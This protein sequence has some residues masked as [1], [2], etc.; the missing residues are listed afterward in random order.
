MQ[1]GAI[2]PESV[3]EWLRET[4]PLELERLYAEADRV[5]CIGVGDEVHLRGLIEI[6]NHCVRQCGY[7][8]LRAA[9]T[10]LTRYRMGTDDVL[11]C[12]RQAAQLGYGTAVLQAGEDY[13]LSGEWIAD[14]VRRIKSETSVAV[15]LSLGERSEEDLALWKKAGA[16][17]YLLRFETSDCDLYNLIHPSLPGGKSDRI[18]LLQKLHELGYEI[19]GGVMVGI[20][21]QSYGSLAEDI[22]TFQRLDLDMIG[23]GPFIPHPG[24]PLGKGEWIRPIAPAEQVPNTEQMVYKTLALARLF[25]PTANLPATTA[26]ATLNQ[27]GGRELALCRGANVIMPNLT[28]AS[29]RALYEIY[30]NKA[31]V[32]ETADHCHLCLKRLLRSIGRKPGSGQGGRQKSIRSSRLKTGGFNDPNCG[33]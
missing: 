9:N 23:I 12:V 25:C 29:Y 15:T 6:S 10:N 24:T 2:K 13:G 18:G 11:G 30:P 21:G 3:E 32:N 28:P 19:G 20:P 16:D 33:S 26:L 22:R 17:R 14:L 7:C 8:G 5:R 4:N 1:N 27:Q 31:C